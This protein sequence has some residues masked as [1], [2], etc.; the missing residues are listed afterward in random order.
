MF[1]TSYG[2]K[3]IEHSTLMIIFMKPKLQSKNEMLKRFGLK[4][5]DCVFKLRTAVNTHTHTQMHPPLIT[6]CCQL[7]SDW[8]FVLHTKHPAGETHIATLVTIATNS[9][10]P[11]GDQ[12]KTMFLGISFFV[13]LFWCIVKMLRCI[14][15]FKSYTYKIVRVILPWC[16]PVLLICP[17]S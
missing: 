11:T 7:G 9:L 14:E 1:C 8:M 3:S 15:F 5:F 12:I 13:C 10:V 2:G 16:N 4:V 17:K 6:P